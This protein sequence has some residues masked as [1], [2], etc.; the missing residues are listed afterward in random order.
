MIT[1]VL[2]DPA[3]PS[4]FGAWLSHAGTHHVGALAFLFAD[5]FL[6]VGVAVLTGVQASQVCFSLFSCLHLTSSLVYSV[7]LYAILCLLNI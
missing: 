5:F 3:A 1:G 4:S 2:T 7:K 6:F